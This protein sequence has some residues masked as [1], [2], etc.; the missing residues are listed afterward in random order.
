MFRLEI[1]RVL[2]KLSK[3]ISSR[4]CNEEPNNGESC[5]RQFE[6]AEGELYSLL[7]ELPL[8]IGNENMLVLCQAQVEGRGEDFPLAVCA[9]NGVFL[10]VLDGCGGSGGKEYASFGGHTGA[11][12]ASRAV[13]LAAEDWFLNAPLN[14]QDEKTAL[15]TYVDGALQACKAS[16]ATKNMLLGSLSKEFPTTIALFH[17]EMNGEL[18]RFHWCGDSRCYVLNGDG[19][20]QATLDDTA[21]R[22]AMRNLR[23]DAPMTN[24]ASASQPFILHER[25]LKI[26]APAVLIAATDGCF[27]YLPSPMDFERLL[28]ETMLC[29]NSMAEWKRR[30][31]AAIARVSGDDYTLVAYLHGFK[32]FIEMKRALRSRLEYMKAHYPPTASENVLFEQWETY[33]ANYEELLHGNEADSERGYA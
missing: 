11:W 1:D 20:R 2:N 27:G 16:E 13:A 5:A 17:K 22:D 32:G 4:Q 23:E 30:L 21:V 12:V 28:L 25:D 31:D 26:P 29:S 14:E 10:G 15:K 24:V 7:R 9:E 19:L 18:V 6:T 8:P 3:T 33:K